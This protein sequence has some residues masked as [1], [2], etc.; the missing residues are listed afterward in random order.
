VLDALVVTL[1]PF[2]DHTMLLCVKSNLLVQDTVPLWLCFRGTSE[3][4]GVSLSLSLIIVQL[5]RF[6]AAFGYCVS[7]ALKLALPSEYTLTTW[8]PSLLLALN[9][10]FA[11]DTER[12]CNNSPELCNVNYGRAVHLGAHDSP[13]LSDASTGFSSFGN[14][15]YNSTVQLGAGVRLLTAQVHISLNPVSKAHELHLC[16]TSCALFD[17]GSLDK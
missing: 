3:F 7:L 17:V 8:A 12:A 9:A 13:Y 5:P 4:I 10:V 1:S 14:Q 2:T 6:S 16:H 11:S 15:F